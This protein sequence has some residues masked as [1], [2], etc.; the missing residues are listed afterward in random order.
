MSSDICEG[1]HGINHKTRSCFVKSDLED[2][3]DCP[4]GGCLVKVMCSEVCQ[5]R[6]SFYAD[7]YRAQKDAIFV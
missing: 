6:V 4:C 1:C 7:R 5:E 2:Y 3:K